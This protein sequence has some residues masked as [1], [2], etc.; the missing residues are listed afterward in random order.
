MKNF[1]C[2]AKC[3]VELFFK[4]L[5]FFAFSFVL[6]TSKGD[7]GEKT[8]QQGNSTEFKM[9]LVVADTLRTAKEIF[10]VSGKGIQFFPKNHFYREWHNTFLCHP[11]PKGDSSGAES[12]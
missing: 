5:Q 10:H 9:L 6:N 11:S 7:K 12:S 8:H 1:I 4:F 3:S 2:G